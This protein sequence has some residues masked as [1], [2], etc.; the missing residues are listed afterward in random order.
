[1]SA[2]LRADGF[3]PIESIKVTRAVL[4]LSLGEAKRLSSEP[5]LVKRARRVRRAY[6]AA[7]EAAAQLQA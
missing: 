1:M 5:R 3:S 4:Q 6:D 7:F 2:Q